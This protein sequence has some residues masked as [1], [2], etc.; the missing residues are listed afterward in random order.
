MGLLFTPMLSWNLAKLKLATQARKA[1]FAIKAYQKQFGHF[2]HSEHFKLFD[3]IIK[4]ILLY[5]KE[6]WGTSIAIEIEIE[7]V[8]FC[9]ELLGVNKT[10]NEC[11]VFGECGRLPLCSE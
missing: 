6:I 11:M 1:I 5:G 7:Q 2:P 10:T 4:P 9:K 3:S 8:K